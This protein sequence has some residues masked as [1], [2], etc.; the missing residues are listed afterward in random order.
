LCL[1]GLWLRV[2]LESRG[3]GVRQVLIL[4]VRDSVCA[5]VFLRIGSR[6]RVGAEMGVW[7][8][9]VKLRL[10]V[11]VLPCMHRR[12][13]YCEVACPP[14]W[15]DLDALAL[16]NVSV[17]VFNPPLEMGQL[18]LDAR[19]AH[20]VPQPKGGDAHDGVE[21]RAEGEWVKGLDKR[22]VDLLDQHPEVV[23]ADQR[24]QNLRVQVGK[25]GCQVARHHPVPL[26]ADD[27][28][29][30]VQLRLE[31]HMGVRMRKAG[32]RRPP[33]KLGLV[34]VVS[35]AA[36]VHRGA[37]RARQRA[38]CRAMLL[39]GRERCLDVALACAGRCMVAGVVVVVCRGHG[40]S[41][42]RCRRRRLRRVRLAPAITRKGDARATA[43]A[44]L[45]CGTFD[46]ER[47]RRRALAA[48]APL[49]ERQQRILVALA[50][51]RRLLDGEVG[52]LVARRRRLLDG[53][54]ARRRVHR[55]P[56]ARGWRARRAGVQAAQRV[57]VEDTVGERPAGGQRRRR[58]RHRRRGGRA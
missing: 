57:E 25:G 7:D 1:D 38:A 9:N 14:Q 48:L 23:L 47:R 53:E 29:V 26:Y 49:R 31:G 39:V 12:G 28:G 50:G 43:Y 3:E 11:A 55:V 18:P 37:A 27:A 51:S 40:G 5:L 10:L 22:V 34:V 56:E 24:V 19:Q 2:D 16:A 36:R 44:V 13:T 6:G 21:A 52:I 42:C 45:A 20:V 30:V 33:G 41:R 54:R 17:P 4:Q 46:S 15:N 58:R 8:L 32:V 35:A